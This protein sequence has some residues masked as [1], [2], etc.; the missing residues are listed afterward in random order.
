[1]GAA[2]AQGVL[3]SGLEPRALTIVEVSESRRVALTA[4]FP[5]ARIVAG[6]EACERVVVAVKPPDVE[7]AVTE[8]VRYGARSVVSIAAGISLSSLSRAAG[9]G[10]AVVRAMPNTPSLVGEGAAA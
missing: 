7:G 1:M 2:L 10:V 8:A 3:R 5:E 6:I 4:M 9:P